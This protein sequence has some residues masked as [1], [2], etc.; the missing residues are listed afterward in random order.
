MLSSGSAYRAEEGQKRSPKA[1]SFLEALAPIGGE[2]MH[3]PSSAKEKNVK[4][5]ACVVALGLEF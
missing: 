3:E 5:G 1:S 2:R 4:G